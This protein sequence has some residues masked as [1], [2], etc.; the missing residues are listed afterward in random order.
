MYIVQCK[1][2]SANA[3]FRARLLRASRLLAAAA[4]IEPRTAADLNQSCVFGL[5]VIPAARGVR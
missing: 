1:N 4:T 3:G 2:A 5:S